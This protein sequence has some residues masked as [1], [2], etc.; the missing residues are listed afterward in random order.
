MTSGALEPLSPWARAILAAELVAA[1]PRL[2]GIWLR[3]R[4][5]PV[6]DKFL[7]QLPCPA[8][9]IHP[10]ISDEA[11][12]GGLDVSQTLAQGRLTRTKGLLETQ[13]WILLTM[14]ERCPPG[15]AARLAAAVDRGTTC[16]AL[17]E[18]ADDNEGL[19]TALADRLA[20]HVDLEG[21]RL[22]ETPSLR[23]RTPSGEAKVTSELL[24]QLAEASAAFGVFSIR[25]LRQTILTAETLARLE[26]AESVSPDHVRRA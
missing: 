18:A 17:D 6:R 21:L 7:S 10:S 2:G 16:L 9:K 4:S 5:G 22:A 11:L 13:D 24:T 25:T 20:F 19:P 3:A 1:E 8:R 12:F 14:A 26:N 15:L 23:P